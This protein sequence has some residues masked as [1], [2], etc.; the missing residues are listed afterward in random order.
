MNPCDA[1]I[2][3]FRDR[4]LSPGLA[5]PA[6]DTLVKSLIKAF[7][8]WVSIQVKIKVKLSRINKTIEVNLETGSTI[9]D[10]L[11]KMELES[12][13][14]TKI[15]NLT[16]NQILF[17]KIVRAAMFKNALIVIDR[18]FNQCNDHIDLK[19]IRK[20]FNILDAFFI[21]CDILDYSWNKEKYR[22]LNG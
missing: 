16:K 14:K 18:P 8:I 17:V 3:G 10:L 6:I 22:Q 9:E 11:K 13:S 19:K 2:S 12:I 20:I 21:K 15:A 1:R 5:T 7:F 4:R